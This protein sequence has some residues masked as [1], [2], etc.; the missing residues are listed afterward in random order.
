MII[1]ITANTGNHLLARSFISRL[2]LKG[3]LVKGYT[4]CF[5]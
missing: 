5:R 3:L 1:I 4:S 2:L